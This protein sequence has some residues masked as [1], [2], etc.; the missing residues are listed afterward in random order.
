M[1]R[2]GVLGHPIGHS[3]SPRIHNAWMQATGVEGHYEAIDCQAQEFV[4]TVRRLMAEGWSGVNVTLPH[5][6]RAA[7]IADQRS[8]IVEKV[9]AS[10]LLLFREGVIH[11]DNTDGVGFLAGMPDEGAFAPL[12]RDRA[13]ILGAGG[14]AA[15]IA[16]VL[17]FYG[18][19][20]LVNR[21]R[22]RAEGLAERLA[23][24]RLRVADWQ[25]RQAEVAGA[26]LVVNATSLGM[27]GQP[28]LDIDI[29]AMEPS[30]A[31]VDIVY[32]PLKTALI[33][34]AEELGIAAA[35]GLGMLVGQAIPSFRA[36]TGREPPDPAGIRK[37]L[38]AAL[39]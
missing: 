30:G 8:A 31:V 28:P 22:H 4:T 24:P 29:A 17:S 14:A 5:K 16:Y 34:Q 11:A 37:T 3:L 19:T 35:G 6:E 18:E 9:G 39:S 10:N 1:I 12:K 36:I 2:A 32:R 26:D 7:A 27:E 23:Q 33:R 38:E 13:V 15:P 21:T 25:D 20:V